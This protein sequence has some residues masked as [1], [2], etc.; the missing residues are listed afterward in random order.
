MRINGECCDARRR[1][2]R[3]FQQQQKWFVLST[4][5]IMVLAKCSRSATVHSAVGVNETRKSHGLARTPQFLVSNVFPTLWSVVIWQ[6]VDEWF[7]E[8]VSDDNDVYSHFCHCNN[9][10]PNNI[11]I[12]HS[13]NVMSSATGENH[14]SS[15]SLLFSSFFL[16]LHESQIKIKWT[17]IRKWCHHHCGQQYY[18]SQYGQISLTRAVVANLWHNNNSYSHRTSS[19][20]RTF[21]NRNMFSLFFFVVVEKIEE[22]DD[23]YPG[24]WK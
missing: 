16:L 6:R 24:S 22:D 3:L 2:I 4:H 20:S 10:S 23:I 21:R 7:F 5:F 9:K 1:H 11:M 12:M 17:F 13:T 14:V 8:S 18:Y 19:K 15:L